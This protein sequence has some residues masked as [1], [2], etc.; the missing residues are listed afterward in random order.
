[1]QL[2]SSTALLMIS[3]GFA[4]TAF[5]TGGPESAFTVLNADS[6]A[7]TLVANEYIAARSIPPANVV[8]LHDLPSF[9]EIK[10]DQFRD[11]IL[12]PILKTAEERGIAP[13]IDCIL[14]SADYLTAIDI[15][16]LSIFTKIKIKTSQLPEDSFEV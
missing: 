2:K 11:L 5:A 10:V 12:K 16:S 13:Q 1:M 14:Y 9:E 8:Y 3:L 15:T 6:W 4:P 7:S